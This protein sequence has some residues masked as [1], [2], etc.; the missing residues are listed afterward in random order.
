LFVAGLKGQSQVSVN[1]DSLTEKMCHTFRT[2]KFSTDSAKVINMFSKHL[3]PYS[4]QLS[5]QELDSV[6][7]KCFF[8]LQLFC[9]EFKILLE[10][11]DENKAD[12]TAIDSL[13]ESMAT[14]KDCSD[15]FAMKQL[16]Y[17]EPGGDSTHVVITSTS[18]EDH[19]R[20]GT[21]S[22]LSLV[23]T[24]DFDFELTFIESTN[25]T[26]KNLSNAGDRYHYRILEKKEKYYVMLLMIPGNTRRYKFKMYFS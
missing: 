10:Q 9:N 21:I 12:W 20:D 14:Q 13:P 22:K 23:R 18:W 17:L 24:S 16:W 8:R 26:R 25:F 3:A 2:E 1:V 15:F 7:N 4:S 5:Q 19:F 6:F 11:L